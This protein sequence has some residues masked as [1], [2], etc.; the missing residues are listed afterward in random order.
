MRG[1]SD[2]L[3]GDSKLITICGDMRYTT[4]MKRERLTITS[5]SATVT[6]MSKNTSVPKPTPQMKAVA[7]GIEDGVVWVTCE[8]PLYGAVNGYVRIPESHPWHGLDYDDIDVNVHGGLT[9]GHGDWVGF[10]CMH[11]GD[12]WPGSPKHWPRNGARQWTPELVAQET[13]KLAKAVAAA[14][15]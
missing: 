9:Y 1:V 11:L 10:D 4:G 7:A 8:A 3:V 6:R 15:K 14:E 12:Y 5:N 2:F 13:R